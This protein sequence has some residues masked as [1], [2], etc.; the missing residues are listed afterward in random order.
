[1]NSKQ[2]LFC[3]Y[4]IELGNGAEAA[5]RAG[6]AANSAR[7]QA[8]RLLTNEDISK[9]IS[10][11]RKNMMAKR[12]IQLDDLVTIL[13]EIANSRLSDTIFITDDGSV[14][15]KANGNLDVLAKL[16]F[17]KNDNGYSLSI[18]REDRIRAIKELAR[19]YGFYAEDKLDKSSSRKEMAISLLNALEKF[20][21]RS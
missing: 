11:I 5:K 18:R 14:E 8:S 1:M 20:K 9:K 13:W 7:K 4:Y 6:Y 17:S 12:Q 10:E 19:I 16:A 2:E 3:Y 21:K 15:L